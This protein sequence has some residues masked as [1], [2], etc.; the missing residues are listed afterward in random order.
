MCDWIVT[1]LT[2]EVQHLDSDLQLEANFSNDE[3][4][5]E[6]KNQQEKT[7]TNHGLISHNYLESQ[8]GLHQTFNPME[9]FS[10]GAD[11]HIVMVY[12]LSVIS[13]GL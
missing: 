6:E 3:E 2:H 8:Y 7:K 9:V 11:E 4:E 13:A 12:R 1:T 5:Q 10:S